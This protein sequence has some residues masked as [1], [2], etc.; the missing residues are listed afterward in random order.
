MKMGE[1]TRIEDVLK[2]ELEAGRSIVIRGWVRTRRDSKAGFSFVQVHDGSSF[3]ADVLS[4]ILSL[5][6][7]MSASS[8]CSASLLVPGPVKRR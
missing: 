6:N 2:G 1:C 7:P 5:M 4:T 8:Q 3:D